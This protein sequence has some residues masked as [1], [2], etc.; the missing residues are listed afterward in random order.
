MT[1][2]VVG[3]F[4][5]NKN[6]SYLY[7]VIS[8]N[9][10]LLWFKIRKQSIFQ[11]EISDSSLAILLVIFPIAIRIFD[12]IEEMKYLIIFL[13][14]LGV[15]IKYEVSKKYKIAQKNFRSSASFKQSR[16]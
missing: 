1:W 3:I 13:T 7:L 9:L 12:S 10:I 14:V 16:L 4:L 11:I 5:V 6:F 2:F 8:G 15:I